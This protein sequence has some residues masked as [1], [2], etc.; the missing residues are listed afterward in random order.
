MR[1]LYIAVHSH[2]GWGAEYWVNQ[3]LQA[4]GVETVL[5]DYRKLNSVELEQQ[6]KQKARECDLVFLQRGEKVQ[7]WMLE[8]VKR[9]LVFW[10]TE[11]IS[12]KK[13]VDHLL[14]MR[15]FSWV[16]VHSFQCLKR[17]AREFPHLVPTASV[18]H[19]ATPS[20]WIKPALPS[21]HMAIFNRTLSWRRRFWL[22]YCRDWCTIESRK[23]GEDY[24]NA[25]RESEIALNIHYSRRNLGDI[26]TGI[27]EALAAGCAVLT[28]RLDEKAVTELQLEE[29]LWQ[30]DSPREM[31]RAL[32]TLAENEPL[33]QEYRRRAREAAPQHTWE[34]RVKQILTVFEK[35]LT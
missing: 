14:R 34:V 30:V 17:I 12:L 33:R 15:F 1:V 32:K 21:K 4:A 2:V 24:L 26:E 27:F 31:R 9:P 16:F 18:L 20:S 28:E 22:W 5:L 35:D 23:Y 3:A 8:D 13:D 25:L 10:S 11:P 19:N 7:P 6:I 29:V